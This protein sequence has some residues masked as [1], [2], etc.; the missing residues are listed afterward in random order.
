MSANPTAA[1][2]II[3]DEILSGRTT[4]T[5]VNTIAKFLNA[6]GIDLREVRMVHDIEAQ[7]IEAVT[8]V[9]DAYDY[10]FTTGGIGP[11]HDDI[12]ADCIARAFNVQISEHPAA[13]KLLVDRAA[14]MGWELNDNSRRMARIPHGAELIKNPVS[15]AP[16]FQLGNVFVLAGVPKIMTAMLEDVAPRLR[17]G[18]RVLSRTI[19]LT[20][21]GESWAADVLRDIDHRYPD[22]SLGSYP[23]GLL[24]GEFG[25][26]LVVRGQDENDLDAATTELIKR[27]EPIVAETQQRQP[28]AS[29][30]EL[31]V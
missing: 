9:R 6:L 5:N 2:I 28:L 20:Y 21:V 30:E 17:T 26:H 29:L 31:T 22:L 12:T 14:K 4:D 1:I 24:P 11:T 19:K 23:Y 16:G 18:R 7:I 15:A 13:L 8:A 3:G 25:T 27:L 10:I